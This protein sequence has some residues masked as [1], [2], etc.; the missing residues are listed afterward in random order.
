MKRH[1]N[2]A[3]DLMNVRTAWSSLNGEA[4]AGAGVKIAVLDT[5]IDQNHAAFQE[6][7]LQYPAGFP[8][9]ESSYTNRK[10]ISARSYVN[11]LVGTDPK[12]TRP[13][14]LSPRDRVGHGTAVAMIAAGGQNTGPVAT[15]TGVAPRAWLGNYKVLGRLG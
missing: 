14:D 15:I 7:G 5:G 12:F 2:R 1:L 6:N 10:V 4:N 8:K 13:D 9:G 3:L 11:M